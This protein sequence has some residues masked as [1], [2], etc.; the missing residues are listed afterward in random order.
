M[1]IPGDYWAICQRTGI[2]FRI[3]ELREEATKDNPNSG[4]WV[5]S[6]SVDPVNPQEYVRG[7][8]DDPSVPLSF[9]DVANAMGETALSYATPQNN[10]VV[11][12]PASA[13]SEGDP[14]GIIMD[15]GNIF[16]DFAETYRANSEPMW[17]ANGVLMYASDGIMLAL[18]NVYDTIIISSGLFSDAASGNT[19]YLP[20]LDNEEWQ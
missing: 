12:L 18:S 16:W 3:S 6:G 14:V 11:V 19:V 4:T 7:V 17:D 9:G 5:Y 2:K 15:D 8:E 10:Q 1:Y 13:I 20:S